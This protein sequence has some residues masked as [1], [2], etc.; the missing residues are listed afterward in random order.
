MSSNLPLT[1]WQGKSVWVVGA[2]SG[3]GQATAQALHAQGATVFVSA[4]NA[5]ALTKF[6][7][8]HAGAVALPLDVTNAAAVAVTAAATHHE[9][10]ARLV[11][12]FEHLT[13]DRV[14]QLG[15]IYSPHVWFK[16]PFNEVRV[17]PE[18]HRR[19]ADRLSPGLL[20]RGRR[21]V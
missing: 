19:R 16:D 12:F 14:Q 11:N 15:T 13:A 4:R 17:T 21:A 10:V 1:S 2:S 3:I 6:T 5:D 7:A 9:P 20:G 18:V 8:V